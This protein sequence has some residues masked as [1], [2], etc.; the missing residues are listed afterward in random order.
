[1]Y[2]EDTFASDDGRDILE[3][4]I[5]GGGGTDFMCNWRYMK[6]QDIVPKKFIMFTDGMTWDSWGDPDYC[7]TVFVIHSVHGKA[8]ESPFGVTTYYND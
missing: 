2:S 4:E 3:Y 8:P 7:E 6:D 1:V 5:A